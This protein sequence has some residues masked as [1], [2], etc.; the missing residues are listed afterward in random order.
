MFAERNDKISTFLFFHF[1]HGEG[2]QNWNEILFEKPWKIRIK[3][4]NKSKNIVTAILWSRTNTN[5]QQNGVHILTIS[6]T[7]NYINKQFILFYS[8]LWINVTIYIVKKHY[9][10]L[11][12][13]S[14]SVFV[15]V[16]HLRSTNSTLGL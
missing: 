3:K 13:S 4:R 5:L 12:F 10:S 11:Y 15:S 9:I 6:L 2:N 1:S 14:L 16:S 7:K 8:L